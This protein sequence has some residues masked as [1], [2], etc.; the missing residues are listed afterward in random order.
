MNL[1]RT[2]M[3]RGAA[4]LAAPL[5][6]ATACSGNDT[7]EQADSSTTTTTPSGPTP[8][9]ADEFDVDGPLDWEVWEPIIEKRHESYQTDRDKN[10]RVEDGN[11]VIE[12]HQ[13]DYKDAKYTSAMIQTR[14]SFQYGRFEA[15]MKLPET[16]GTWP[17]FWL[18][19]DDQWPDFGEIDVMEHFARETETKGE[20][21]SM[22]YVET[23]LHSTPPK[24]V[25]ALTDWGRAKS[26]QVDVAEWH[27]Y[28][29]EWAEGEIRFFIDDEETATHV[30][31]P[32]GDEQTWPFDD[33]PEV[34]AFDMFLGAYAG[35]VDSAALPQQLLVDWV[36]VWPLDDAAGEEAP[37][38]T[39]P[40]STTQSG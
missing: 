26:T 30:R 29:V 23:N 38:D 31:P 2:R 27:T 8:R 40:P 33:H 21:Q 15:R 25:P 37:D 13:E 22:G 16:P 1:R 36:R 9:F 11:L 18:V 17:A 10:V 34:I 12:A 6:I 5:L 14:E 4:L 20:P 24:A 39:T 35:E 19:N 32:K 3:T 28:A 7:N